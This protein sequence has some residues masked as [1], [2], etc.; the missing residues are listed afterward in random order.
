MCVH[1]N[2]CSFVLEKETT[3]SMHSSSQTT[4]NLPIKIHFIQ[5][6]KLKQSFLSFNTPFKIVVNDCW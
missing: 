2:Y 1:N 6:G 3:T 4:W 5:Q